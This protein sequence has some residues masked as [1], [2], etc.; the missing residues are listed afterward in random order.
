MVQAYTVLADIKNRV[1]SQQEWRFCLLT[2]AKQKKC[3]KEKKKQLPVALKKK[4]Q[5]TMCHLTM[6]AFV[7][8]KN[9][10]MIAMPNVWLYE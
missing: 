7:M 4:D 9:T 1:N 10:N 3:K 8:L 6:Q 5:S 2:N